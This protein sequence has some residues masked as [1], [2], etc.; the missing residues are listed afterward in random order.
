[1]TSGPAI[2]TF[3]AR[4]EWRANKLTLCVKGTELSTSR[5]DSS[6]SGN[7]VRLVEKSKICFG[8][9]SDLRI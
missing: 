1:M 5:V 6:R 2:D 9:L 7:D 3:E 8:W 4:A